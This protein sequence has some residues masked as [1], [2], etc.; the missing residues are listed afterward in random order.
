MRTLLT[1]YKNL[2]KQIPGK[3]FFFNFSVLL[4][5][6]CKQDHIKFSNIHISNLK[7]D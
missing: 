6:I 1:F 7:F 4:C 5:N 3:Q 2:V